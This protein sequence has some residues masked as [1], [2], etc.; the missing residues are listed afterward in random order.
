[1]RADE[2]IKELEDF[3]KTEEARQRYDQ[4]GFSPKL[5][6]LAAISEVNGDTELLKKCYALH[7]DRQRIRQSNEARDDTDRLTAEVERA[8]GLLPAT[9]QADTQGD[10]SLESKVEQ[11]MTLGVKGC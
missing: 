6:R 7:I 4:L 8:M 9:D 1:M 5:A 10:D 3:K 11:Y 2:Y